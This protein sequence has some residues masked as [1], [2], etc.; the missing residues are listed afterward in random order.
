MENKGGAF[1]PPFVNKRG[2]GGFEKQ[3]GGGGRIVPCRVYPV[4]SVYPV[5][6]VH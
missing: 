4:Y 1:G 3:G 2:G 5:Y 6:L